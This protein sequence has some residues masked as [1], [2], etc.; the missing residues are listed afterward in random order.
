VSFR[1][2]RAIQRN[3]VS[4]NQNQT[5]PRQDKTKQK[6]KQKKTPKNKKPKTNKQTK[7][8]SMAGR[9]GTLIFATSLPFSWPGLH[10]F[11]LHFRFAIN[12]KLKMSTIS[13]SFAIH[14]CSV[15]CQF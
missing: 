11:P 3:P 6:Q 15:N 13:M 1:T 14:L 10:L 8:K 5:K 12:A 2:A 7:T 9:Q 4:K